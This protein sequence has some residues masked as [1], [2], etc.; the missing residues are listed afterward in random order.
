MYAAPPSPTG[1]FGYQ[2]AGKSVSC[3]T[4]RAGSGTVLLYA[5][6]LFPTNF[7]LILISIYGNIETGVFMNTVTLSTENQLIIPREIC[8][9]LAV[10]PGTS[11]EVISYNNR[12]ELIPISPV[13][14]LKGIFRGIDTNIIR[15]NDR[16]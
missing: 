7:L 10:K 12:I 9:T 3:T 8:E 14:Q 13:Q 15:D 2:A 6:P 16:I 5:V 11:F 4:L 1:D